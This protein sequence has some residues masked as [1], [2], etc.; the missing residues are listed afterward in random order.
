MPRDEPALSRVSRRARSRF[1][2]ARPST[3]GP[4]PTLTWLGGELNPDLKR[5]ERIR[6]VV[7]TVVAASVVASLVAWT[8]TF[9]QARELGEYQTS[10]EP[11][12][13]CLAFDPTLGIVAGSLASAVVPAAFEVAACNATMP[14][15]VRAPTAGELSA[16]ET[17]QAGQTFETGTNLLAGGRGALAVWEGV[18]AAGGETGLVLTYEFRAGERVRT[19][20]ERADGTEVADEDARECSATSRPFAYQEADPL[21]VALAG[22]VHVLGGGAVSLAAGDPMRSGEGRAASA[23]ALGDAYDYL[24]GAFD[25]LPAVA[26]PGESPETG[27]PLLL[28][29]DDGPDGCGIAGGGSAARTA[30]TRVCTFPLSSRERGAAL[31]DT[32]LAVADAGQA[33]LLRARP[34]TK[35]AVYAEVLVPALGSALCRNIVRPLFLES[36]SVGLSVLLACLATLPLFVRWTINRQ[37]RE[38]EEAGEPSFEEEAAA[39]LSAARSRVEELFREHVSDEQVEHA[40]AV[41][42]KAEGVLRERLNSDGVELPEAAEVALAE[43]KQKAEEAVAAVQQSAAAAVAPPAAPAPPPAP[44]PPSPSPPPASSGDVAVAVEEGD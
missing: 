1:E 17:A 44:A 35:D 6:H 18:T 37:R 39:V 2:S 19:R 28:N 43:V 16:C 3:A 10:P 38:A 29:L 34:G 42:A 5:P 30:P 24:R 33:V 25:G 9:A 36:F 12:V 32:N 7:I 14:G 22:T 26:E 11:G 23:S 41:A 31:C 13:L 8:Y 21:R 40:R 15:G 27:G 4:R 20:L